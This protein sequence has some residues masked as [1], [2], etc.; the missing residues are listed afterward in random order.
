VA[1]PSYFFPNNTLKAQSAAFALW[2]SGAVVPVWTEKA[3]YS[4]NATGVFTALTLPSSATDPVIWSDATRT[5]HGYF[6]CA[7][8]GVGGVW[9]SAD[10]GKLAYLPYPNTS[11]G[12]IVDTPVTEAL[13][14]LVVTGIASS[15]NTAIALDASGNIYTST[16]RY[17]GVLNTL[18]VGFN[19][20]CKGLSTDNVN[21]YT[22]EPL[23]GRLGIMN[24]VSRAV[25]YSATPMVLPGIVA[26]S[27]S[28]VAVG[29]WSYASLPSGAIAFAAS[30]SAA[31]TMAAFAQPAIVALLSGID[32]YWT[33][34]SQLTGLT[35]CTAIAWNPDDSQILASVASGVT[36]V[37]VLE[38]NLVL[39][40]QLSVPGAASVAITPDGSNA[41]VCVPSSNEITV[42]INDLDIWSVGTSFAIADPVAVMITSA[43][44]GWAISGT[45]VYPLIRA[46]NVWST[47]PPLALGF[48]GIAVGEDAYGNVYITGGTG[49]TGYLA[50]IDSGAIVDTVTWTGDG[51]GISM[52]FE[53]GQCAVLLSD[54]QT[55]RAFGVISGQITEEGITGVAVPT[56]CSFIGGTPSS[57]WLCGTSAIEQC[58]WGKPYALHRYRTGQIG[59]YNGSSWA[60]ASLGIFHDP[61][62]IAWDASGN[63]WVATAENDL[64]AFSSTLTQTSYNAIP[65]YTGQVPGTMMGISSLTWWN[66]SLYATTLFPGAVI[67]I[68]P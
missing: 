3:A 23:V 66:D 60:S 38:G 64:Y 24:L 46:G 19:T 28:G 52:T 10:Y 55:I 11:S 40:Q 31:S 4:M 26:A 42:L 17:P 67:N 58:W 41:L 21:L 15:G 29:G 16:S 47:E 68:L 6:G 20:L 36:V 51:Y 50:I 63:I 56:G 48:T 2:P 12:F 14:G 5:G 43:T 30:S 18:P 7:A 1:S 35:S 53:L 34:S 49:T 27:A 8:D 39:D 54:N 13:V 61:S 45:N 44:A 57:V 32:P 33:I 37:G 65:D 9:M 59:L 25:S 22:A 62:A